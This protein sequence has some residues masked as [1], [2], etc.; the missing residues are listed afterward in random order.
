MRLHQ[1]QQ[2]QGTHFVLLAKFIQTIRVNKKSI[3]KFLILFWMRNG[4]CSR[5]NHNKLGGQQH[6]STRLNANFD[7]LIADKNMLEEYKKQMQVYTQL[8][9]SLAHH[10]SRRPYLIAILLKSAKLFINLKRYYDYT[11]GIK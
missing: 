2:E 10:I 4:T 8:C 11:G 9:R 1:Q 7:K 6:T 3:M 5:D